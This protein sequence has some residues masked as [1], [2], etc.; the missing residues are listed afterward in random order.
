MMIARA[1]SELASK[2]HMIH[3]PC[4]KSPQRLN[5]FLQSSGRKA[6]R[7]PS[8]VEQCQRGAPHSG[9]FGGSTPR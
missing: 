3:P 8:A 6:A 1:A 4:W 7:I 9:H 2:G 5:V